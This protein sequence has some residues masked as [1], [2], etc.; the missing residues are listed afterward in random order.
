VYRGGFDSV[1]ISPDGRFIAAGTHNGTLHLFE[2]RSARTLVKAHDGAIESLAFSADGTRLVSA[3][4]DGMKL[5][6]T[7]HSLMHRQTTF[8]DKSRAPDARLRFTRDGK[9]LLITE[10]DSIHVVDAARAAPDGP[11]IKCEGASLRG[12]A[13]HPD[14]RTV[15][16]G[17]FEHRLF[18]ADLK[19]RQCV[20]RKKA[21][22]FMLTNANWVTA[23]AFSPDGKRL[24]SGDTEGAL[25]VSHVGKTLR[26]T[27]LREPEN[28][29]NDITS[30]VWNGEALHVG[31]DDHLWFTSGRSRELP[32]R[33]LVT[34]ISGDGRLIAG[35]SEDRLYLWEAATRRELAQ[36][37]IEKDDGYEDPVVALALSRD[38]ALLAVT[39]RRGR[40]SL[41]DVAEDRWVG[42]LLRPHGNGEVRTLDFNPVRDQLAAVAGN[43]VLIWDLDPQFWMRRAGELANRT[44][45]DAERKR[46][47]RDQ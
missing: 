26:F 33:L 3:A 4:E 11:A 20:E 39:R 35:A 18:F 41:F 22:R 13:V 2:H 23:L 25:V 15:A 47:L 40:V 9:R 38:G 5:W 12:L 29:A 30:M 28:G 45:S 42:D 34:A 24:A 31:G 36:F 37:P 19:T 8:L 43:A 46:Y 32:R 10:D 14:G 16:A 44:L 17:S 21:G 27:W 1:A 7:R 6:Q